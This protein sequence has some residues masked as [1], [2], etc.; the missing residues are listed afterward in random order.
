MVAADEVSSP[1]TEV[2]CCYIFWIFGFGGFWTGMGQ[3][4]NRD[5]S[6]FFFENCDFGTLVA[7]DVSGAPP[8]DS[9]GFVGV[10][11]VYS[12]LFGAPVAHPAA[13]TPQNMRKSSDGTRCALCVS[14]LTPLRPK[15]A[16]TQKSRFRTLTPTWRF[17]DTPH[18]L[19]CV[20]GCIWPAFGVRLCTCSTLCFRKLQT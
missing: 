11:G 5:S 18:R 1:Q 16:K 13:E 8:I 9:N 19:Q 12:E 4:Q 3:P 10:F 6:V 14:T 2:T 17:G 15:K 20:C 7:A